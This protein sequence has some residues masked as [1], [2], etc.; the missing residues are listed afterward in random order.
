MRFTLISFLYFK[1]NRTYYD[2][3]AIN[4]VRYVTASKT[5][6]LQSISD[7]L[8]FTGDSSGAIGDCKSTETDCVFPFRYRGT[9]H[10]GCTDVDRGD[11]SKWC[12]TRVDRR[13]KEMLDNFW[14][15]C[16]MTS[17]PTDGEDTF[18]ALKTKTVVLKLGLSFKGAWSLS[19]SATT[20]SASSPLGGATGSRIV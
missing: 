20:A 1:L 4:V 5:R 9:W 12:A 10:N 8:D 15:V 18:K 17:C 2:V 13:T 14:G 6:Q 3:D 19:S 16:K 11:G 7:P